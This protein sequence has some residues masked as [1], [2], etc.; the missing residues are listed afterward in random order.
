MKLVVD[1]LDLRVYEGNAEDWAMAEHIDL[2]FT[3][4]YGYLPKALWRHPMIIHQWRH[5][6]DQAEEWCGNVLDFQVSAW[7]NDREVFWAANIEMP[8][9]LELRNYHPEPGGWYPEELV[10]DVLGRYASRGQTIW[11]GFMG[12]GTIAKICREQGLYYVGV[13]QLPAHIALAKTYLGLSE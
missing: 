10:R 1:T 6:R 7:N 3:N 4:P 8:T 11:D 2:V 9:T 5:R 12:R 13:E